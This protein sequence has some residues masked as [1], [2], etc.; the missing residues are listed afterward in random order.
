M[1]IIKKRYLF[2]LW[3]FMVAFFLLFTCSVLIKIRSSTAMQ[4]NESTLN[5]IYI[6]QR[7]LF[8]SCSI[9]NT[10]KYR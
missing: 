4:I 5:S 10:V 3:L 8:Y 2:A 6:L 1:D 9:V 7:P